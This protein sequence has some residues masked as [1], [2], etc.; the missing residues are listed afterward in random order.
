MRRTL[1]L[2]TIVFSVV[3]TA[4]APA[5]ALECDQ[6]T[7]PQSSL[8]DMSWA[9]DAKV[10]KELRKVVL[11]ANQSRAN[12]LAKA[13]LAKSSREAQQLRD[14]ADDV[15]SQAALADALYDALAG[16]AVPRCRIERW[17]ED[18]DAI[19]AAFMQPMPT[20]ES[21]YGGSPFQL[22]LLGLAPTMLLNDQY[23][24]V[25][26]IGHFFQQ[27]HEYYNRY[28]DARHHGD[29]EA[30]ATAIAIKH[31]VWQENGFYGKAIIGIYSNA[32]LAANY[33]GLL[34]Y[35]NL[36]EPIDL[37]PQQI[38]PMVIW[39]G[40]QLVLSNRCKPGELLAP[41][42]TE[43]WNEAMN[44]SQYTAMWRSRVREHVRE[45]SSAWLAFYGSTVELETARL[46][47]MRTFYGQSYG[48][49]GWA[50]LS[51]I[52]DCADPADTPL[53]ASKN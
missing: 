28:S 17:L 16:G 43:H 23:V 19:H 49:S 34:F 21:I 12:Y 30:V 24:G 1:V 4:A 5:V 25:D 31:G 13:A 48:H 45:R 7:V 14:R 42:V 22:L 27:G 44:P 50:G 37:G 33:A 47:R 46:A 9:L 18:S 52:A 6:F 51:T 36:L 38:V 39:K 26:K 53:H 8:I 15:T 40:D 35:R 32:D 11:Q 41:F 10:I 29:E 2:I 20:G 3:T